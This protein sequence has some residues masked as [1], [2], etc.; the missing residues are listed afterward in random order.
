MPLTSP[1]VGHTSSPAPDPSV[2]SP[3][4]PGNGWAGTPLTAP[5]PAV[6]PLGSAGLGSNCSWLWQRWAQDCCP[7]SRAEPLP[8][9]GQ[10]AR[11]SRSQS[12]AR[13]TRGLDCQ[14]PP[15]QEDPCCQER[16]HRACAREP[17]RSHGQEAFL[18]LQSRGAAGL[19]SRR[20][21]HPL[22]DRRR[23]SKRKG[24]CPCMGA[25]RGAGSA[26]PHLCP[27]LPPQGR[28]CALR[29]VEPL[30]LAP[31]RGGRWSSPAPGQLP[32]LRSGDL[33]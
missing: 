15:Q 20:P 33:H 24:F 17:R 21:H 9:S 16:G 19:S 10:T 1:N 25:E 3:C 32:G 18:E 31:R 11:H 29:P 5:F 22:A 7:P 6:G 4:A 27:L 26:L 2:V 13:E 12:S 30:S 8:T 28:C 23:C 14:A